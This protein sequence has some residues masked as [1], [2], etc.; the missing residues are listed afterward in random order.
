MREVTA[1]TDAPPRARPPPGTSY[2]TTVATTDNG[3]SL[4]T[5]ES[6]EKVVKGPSA[7]VWTN[8]E[9]DFILSSSS[10]GGGQ[11]GGHATLLPS[12][13]CCNAQWQ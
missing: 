3:S 6:V 1:T 5:L 7:V 11:K 8:I 9:C 10:F 2:L 13:A 12:H 4:P